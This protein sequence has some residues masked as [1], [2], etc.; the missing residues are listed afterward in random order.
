[1][2]VRVAFRNSPMLYDYL[3]DLPI[4]KGDLVVVPT[5]PAP[6]REFAVV[7]VMEVVE[8]SQKATS[9]VAQKVDVVGFNRR[10]KAIRKMEAML[11]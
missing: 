10:M 1:M 6:F 5:G 4:K 3:C 11:E 2:V 8:H 9:W 7:K